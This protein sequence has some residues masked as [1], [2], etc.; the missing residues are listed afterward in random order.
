MIDSI[1]TN[2]I[3]RQH[4]QNNAHGKKGQEWWQKEKQIQG[5]NF[6]NLTKYDVHKNK[7]KTLDMG[8]QY[9][10]EKTPK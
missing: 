1:K 2:T 10:V 9:A 6:V 8:P 5:N 3:T 7:L 4:G